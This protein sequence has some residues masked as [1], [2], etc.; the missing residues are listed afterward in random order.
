MGDREQAR[1]AL[2]ASIRAMQDGN[3]ADVNAAAREFVYCALFEFSEA[4]KAYRA[5]QAS[6]ELVRE[7]ILGRA[8]DELL[9]EWTG[10]T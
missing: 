4:L 2:S 5:G 9:P 7:T 10:V 6:E 1:A 3:P 8:V